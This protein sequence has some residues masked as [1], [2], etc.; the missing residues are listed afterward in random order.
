MAERRLIV[1]APGH[2]HAAL[3]QREP[4]PGISPEVHVYAPDG[5]ELDDYLA[6]IARYGAGWRLEVRRSDNYLAYLGN[7]AAGGIAVISGRNRGKIER[8]EAAVAAGLHVLADKPMVIRRDELPA[9]ERV[10]AAAAGRGLV[11]RDMMTGRR[12]IAAVLTRHLHG[13]KAVFGEQLPGSAAEPGVEM[14]SVH[15]L[16]KRVSGLPN[17][18]PP[19]YFDVTEQ[20]DALA[21]IGTH[22]VDRVHAALFPAAALDAARDIRIDRVTRWPTPV[23]A[24]QFYEVTGTGA[25][26]EFLAPWLKEGELE[27]PCNARLV[28]AARGVHVGLDLRWDWQEPPGGSDTHTATYRGSRARLELRHGAAEHYRPQLY[29]VPQAEIGQA[30]E[31]RIAALRR[32]YPGIALERRDTEWRVEIPDALRIGHDAAFSAFTR[33][34]VAQCDDPGSVPAWERPNLIAKS[35]VCTAAEAAR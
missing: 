20:G 34:F 29:V 22:L 8:I 24:R 16:M 14:T 4:I 6:R 23:N 2:F 21:D 11:V 12:E 31:H 33:E 15:H 17:L 19:W 28:Y 27:Y 25:W 10:L 5:P 13:D 7:E 26:P 9:L 35:F 18:R 32:D 30:L 1:V 3:V